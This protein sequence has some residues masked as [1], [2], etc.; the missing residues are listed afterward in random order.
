SANV[1]EGPTGPTGPTGP[2]GDAGTTGATGPTGSQGVQGNQGPTGPTG[3][4][5]PSFAATTIRTITASTNLLSTDQ[6]VFCAPTGS[7]TVTMTLP[8][9]A[10][11][12]QGQIYMLKKINTNTGAC[13]VT[14]ISSVDAGGDNTLTLATP[15]A[16][17]SQMFVMSDGST[18]WVISLH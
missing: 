7:G 14:G 5:G 18:W 15:P 9:A 12:N 1:P 16:S 17:A 4:I 10:V 3:P 2:Q 8:A 11:G 6:V 13:H